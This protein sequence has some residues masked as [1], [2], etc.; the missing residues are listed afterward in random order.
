[1]W[2]AHLCA[3]RMAWRNPATQHAYVRLLAPAEDVDEHRYRSQRTI[4]SAHRRQ[5]E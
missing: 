1:M 5:W 3:I 4:I 2:G